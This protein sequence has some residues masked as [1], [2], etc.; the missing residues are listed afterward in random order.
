[1]TSDSLLPTKVRDVLAGLLADRDT[2]AAALAERLS[3]DVAA[4]RQRD[5]GW[6]RDLLA[7]C[8]AQIEAIFGQLDDEGGFDTTTAYRSGRQRAESHIPLSA[9]LDAYRV[10]ARFVWQTL[11]AACRAAEVSSD[12]VVA[13]ADRI[14][15]AQDEFTQAMTTGYREAATAL[16]LTHE[17]ERAA[18]V[19]ALLQGHLVS[20]TML[21]DA[22]AVLRLPQRG[23]FVVVVADV[24]TVGRH[25]L[26][27]VENRLRAADLQS[28]W[29]LRPDT[30]VGIVH[31][32]APARLA[33]L[34]GIL[35]RYPGVRQGISPR[36]EDLDGTGRALRLARIAMTGAPRD[37]RVI[38]FDDNPLTVAA[39]ADPEV[40]RRIADLVLGP[41]ATM[42]TDDRAILL[43]TLEAWL[44]H[45]GSADRTAQQLFCHPNTVRL[46]LRRLEERTGRSLANPRDLTELCLALEAERRLDR[47]A[48]TAPV[49]A[50]HTAPGST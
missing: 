27:G 35:D 20:Q 24:V 5:E 41:L 7:V 47:P 38:V 40:T 19:E 37:G 48:T 32:P 29:R 14:W 26:P 12:E 10:A 18:L 43:D 33:R 15:L 50:S 30:Q 36:Y 6:S 17:A 45:N 39:V 25:A 3:R 44:N 13:I 2:L 1:M 49:E 46:R 11:I 22:A 8:R 34:V 42:R 28:A 9:V 4:Y 16:L 23:P 31:I 21:W